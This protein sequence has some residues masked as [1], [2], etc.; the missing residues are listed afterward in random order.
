MQGNRWEGGRQGEEKISD[1]KLRFQRRAGKSLLALQVSHNMYQ[2]QSVNNGH[3]FPSPQPRRLVAE[4]RVLALS[5]VSGGLVT[6][7]A[8]RGL[9]SSQ[10][11]MESPRC[12]A[13]RTYKHGFRSPKKKR[14]SLCPIRNYLISVNKAVNSVM[15]R[16]NKTL[17]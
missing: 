12:S 13:A 16:W 15:K 4:L 10:S 3:L 14:K 2:I 7:P 17:C 5:Q 11:L 9:H 8:P 1:Q 6:P